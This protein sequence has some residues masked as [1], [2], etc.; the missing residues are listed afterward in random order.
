MLFLLN[1]LGYLETHFLSNSILLS[2]AV[3]PIWENVMLCRI[4]KF[5]LIYLM[6]GKLKIGLNLFF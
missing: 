4:F 6:K 2:G 3:I 5:P 1:K